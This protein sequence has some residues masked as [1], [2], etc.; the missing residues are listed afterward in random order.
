[1]EDRTALVAL[2]LM[3]QDLHQAGIVA[4][5]RGCPLGR[6]CLIPAELA[7]GENSAGKCGATDIEREYLS[8]ARS[9]LAPPAVVG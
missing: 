1:M 9:L 3:I 5:C 2:R 4:D 7:V 8:A 6:T